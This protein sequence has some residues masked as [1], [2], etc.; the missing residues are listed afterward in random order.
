MRQALHGTFISTC[1]PPRRRGLVNAPG[2]EG[3]V[4]AAPVGQMSWMESAAK[5]RSALL[6]AD[7]VLIP[8]QPSRKL[9][10][11]VANAEVD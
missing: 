4:D 7:M 3:T 5:C 9:G 1:H 6:A 11:L 10:L 2:E 8:V